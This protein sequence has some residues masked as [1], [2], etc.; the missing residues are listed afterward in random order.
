MAYSNSGILESKDEKLVTNNEISENFVDIRAT[1]HKKNPKTAK[2]IPGF[3]YRYLQ[4]ITHEK[5]VNRVLYKYRDYSG[6]DFLEKVIIDEFDIKLKVNNLEYF[7]ETERAIVAANH[8]LGGLDGM[9][10]MLVLGRENKNIKF[11]VNDI[12]MG[13]PQLRPV[14][15]PINKIK[16]GSA[17][18]NIS[19]VN[20]AFMSDAVVP[21]FPS[22]MV[23]RKKRFKG[24]K[25][26]PWK[27]S[28]LIGARNHQR[29]I[30]PCH[31]N[32]RNSNFFYNL[33]N[34]RS[35]FGVKANIEMLYLINEMMKQKGK[36]IEITFSKAINPDQLPPAELDL[37]T[38]SNMRDFIYQLDKNKDAKFSAK[39]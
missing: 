33:A 9:A 36:T 32:G 1:F 31:I 21:Y 37:F 22:G 26:L 24:V 23:S 30:I 11:P 38:A 13:V 10:L 29:P 2:R 39:S 8:P 15:V 4:R 17:K 28:Y 16:K 5:E 7:K 34:F 20:E 12:L 25:D 18:Q 3:V 35:F 14:F 27:K 19:N 6:I